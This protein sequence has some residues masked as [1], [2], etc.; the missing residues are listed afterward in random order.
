MAQRRFYNPNLPQTLVIAQIL[1]YMNAVF[2]A[3]A[4]LQVRF[5]SFQYPPIGKV[6]LVTAVVTQAVGAYGVANEKKVGYQI[7]VLAS[8]MPLIS[9][10]VSVLVAG[11]SIT[12]NLSF[13][14][15]SGS[16][17]NALFEYALI[18]LLLHKQS[19]DYQ[20]TWFH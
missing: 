16:I 13:V 8:F 17:L 6:L 19:N 7:A 10:V 14:V 12:R 2:G 3:I 11:A 15:F 4:L 1:L 20:R 9:R 5:G 18:G